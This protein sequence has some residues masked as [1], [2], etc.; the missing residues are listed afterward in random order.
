MQEIETAGIP[1]F[2]LKPSVGRMLARLNK[3]QNQL[4]RHC[5]ISSGYISQLLRGSRCAGPEV[6]ARLL[7]ALPD[8]T[9]DDLFEEVD[10]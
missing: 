4:A 9:F 10:P 3:S 6:R 5:N 2:R 8:A 1:K 7:E